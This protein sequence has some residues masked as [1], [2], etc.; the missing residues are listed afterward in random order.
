M[1]GTIVKDVV[2]SSDGSDINLV[3]VGRKKK[4]LVI[5][6]LQLTKNFLVNVSHNLGTKC[7]L[8]CLNR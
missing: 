1:L 4:K 2:K 8:T 3:I 5:S 7:M 6:I